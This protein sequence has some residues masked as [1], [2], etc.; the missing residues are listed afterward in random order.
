MK[1]LSLLSTFLAT[2]SAAV[3]PLQPV[4]YEGHKV[5]RVAVGN[6]VD[7]VNQIVEK[8]NLQ[9]WKAAKKAGVF[10]DIVVQ[11]AQLDAFTKATKGLETTVMHENLGAAI[12]NE[13][14]S[15]QAFDDGMF[16]FWPA[17]PC[18]KS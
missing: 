1:S 16:I 7:R 13:T 5:F 3:L 6:N 11:P 4:S 15:I 8:L 17:A 2:A 18:R 10:A 12:A 14:S 9:T